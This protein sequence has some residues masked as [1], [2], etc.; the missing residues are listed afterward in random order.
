MSID[1]A[2]ILSRICYT[3]LVYE[4]INKN[5]TASSQNQRLKQCFSTFWKK[6]KKYF[7]KELEKYLHYKSRKKH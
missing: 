1:K 7:F 6:R 3:E 4:R 5:S 2:E